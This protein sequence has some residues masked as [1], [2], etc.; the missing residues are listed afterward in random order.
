MIRIKETVSE[1]GIRILALGE[2]Q[3]EL[4]LQWY[5]SFVEG[6]AEI[7][8]SLE[9][10][11]SRIDC[12]RDDD[13]THLGMKEIYTLIQHHKH[14]K[15]HGEEVIKLVKDPDYYERDEDSIVEIPEL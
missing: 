5:Q 13:P 4:K 10:I 15:E 9:F 3:K 11:Y 7:I 2:I 12:S 8:K 14:N 6:E 1:A